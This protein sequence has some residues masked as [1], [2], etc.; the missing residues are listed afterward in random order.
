[1]I[2]HTTSMI[3]NRTSSVSLRSKIE[4]LEFFP[5]DEFEGNDSLDERMPQ[6][7]ER[8]L[9]NAVQVRLWRMTVS[10]ILRRPRTTA[11]KPLD[12]TDQCFV[13]SQEAQSMLE[14][15]S[16]LSLGNVA[17][18]RSEEVDDALLFGNEGEEDSLLENEILFRDDGLDSENDE[19][20]EDLLSGDCM[21]MEA[22]DME[23]KDWAWEGDYV[24]KGAGDRILHSDSDGEILF[25]KDE[26]IL[27]EGI[28]THHEHDSSTRPMHQAD[29]DEM[30]MSD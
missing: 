1:M 21:T 11:I 15:E 3:H 6:T 13:R 4:A 22:L 14:E 27:L 26:D 20:D 10:K 5:P 19:L 17:S 23:E 7:P 8:V 29:Y 12:W 24:S 9:T 2:A 28:V 16:P 18:F 25:E 30:L